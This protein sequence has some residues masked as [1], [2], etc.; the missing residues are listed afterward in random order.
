MIEEGLKEGLIWNMPLRHSFSL[1][2]L[3][4]SEYGI[5]QPNCGLENVFMS[6]GH[7]G[8]TLWV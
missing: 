1:F 2:C 6:W 8:K 7:D 4:S 5:Y 3:R